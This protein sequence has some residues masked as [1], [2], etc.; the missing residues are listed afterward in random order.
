MYNSSVPYITCTICITYQAEIDLSESKWEEEKDEERSD[1]NE[2]S[3][4]LRM[5][6]KRMRIIYRCCQ[7]DTSCISYMYTDLF[8]RRFFDFLNN[9]QP[10]IKKKN[11]KKKTIKPLNRWNG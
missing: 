10:K 9:R 3:N 1:K 2:N 6:I 7:W 11:E 5:R 8:F 4:G